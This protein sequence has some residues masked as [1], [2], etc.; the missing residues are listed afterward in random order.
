MG[1]RN[2]FSAGD[3]AK[4]NTMYTCNKTNIGHGVTH[5]PG[6]PTTLKPIG[7]IG[8]NPV[9]PAAATSSRP[10]LNFL[11]NLFRP[12]KDEEDG[13]SDERLDAIEEE[14]SNTID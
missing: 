7:A 13:E 9:I 12:R 11:G 6:R 14:S 2:G 1:Q 4:L 5:A 8:A 3:V 10:L